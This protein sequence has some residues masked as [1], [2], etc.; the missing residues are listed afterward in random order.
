[1]SQDTEDGQNDP[2]NAHFHPP[3]PQR[4]STSTAFLSPI[5]TARDGFDYRRPANTSPQTADQSNVIDLTN[6]ESPPQRNRRPSLHPRP[7][8]LPR[9]RLPRFERD[10]LNGTP[11]VVNL[12]D[13]DNDD[14][15]EGPSSSPEVLFVGESVRPRP[16]HLHRFNPMS[17]FADLPHLPRPPASNIAMLTRAHRHRG[18]HGPNRPPN[19][20]THNLETL[21]IGEPGELHLDYGVA[22]FAMGTSSRPEPRRRDTYKAPS[23]APPGFTRTLAD[24]DVAVCPHCDWELGTGDGKKQEIWV[25]K[26]CGHVRL[27]C[28]FW[29]LCNLK[30]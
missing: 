12:D 1:M 5:R 22:S 16:S 28:S 2:W 14:N 23:P 24:D 30:Y 11:E 21:I 18:W 8:N 7:H 3:P 4:T 6:D 26:P 19:I 15:G 10:I 13:D 17:V 25:A 9:T 27:H 20:T 29:P